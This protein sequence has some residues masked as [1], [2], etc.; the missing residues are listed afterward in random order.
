M[1]QSR[2]SNVFE[3]SSSDRV[4][5]VKKIFGGGKQ[6]ERPVYHPGHL[7]VK[8]REIAQS[9]QIQIVIILG[10]HEAKGCKRFQQTRMRIAERSRGS[11]I[12]NLRDLLSC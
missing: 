6:T 9:K 7:N 4:A 1:N 8:D 10:T 11:M 2:S 3:G 5:P 12:R